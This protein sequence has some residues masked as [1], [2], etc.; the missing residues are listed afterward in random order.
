MKVV[1]IT[2]EAYYGAMMDIVKDRRGTDIITQFL[3]DGQ[4]VLYC[5][6]VCVGRWRSVHICVREREGERVRMYVCA[7][8][9]VLFNWLSFFSALFSNVFFLN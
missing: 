1:L 7:C 6:C 4:V 9:F 8:D 3:D 2:P 5:V